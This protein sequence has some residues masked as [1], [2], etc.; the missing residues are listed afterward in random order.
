M[1][2]AGV[3]TLTGRL[4]E[5]MQESA[6]VGAVVAAG[7]RGAVRHRPGL[8]IATPTCICTCSRGAVPKEGASAG[9]T[10]MAALVSAFT[11]RVGRGDMAMTGEI[12][13]VGQ[14]L[15]VGAIKEKV[16]AAHRCG[17]TRVILPQENRKQVDEELGD[18]LRRAVK[19]HYVT[20][21]DEVLEMALRPAPE[22]GD[23]AAAMPTGRV[24]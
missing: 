20:R 2:G 8:P 19:V 14:V 13:L 10:I 21:V 5:V 18:D 12:T 15:P 22:A 9:V 17:L 24:S 16:L 11:G 23:T 3:L 7:Q 4:G 1:S 6:R